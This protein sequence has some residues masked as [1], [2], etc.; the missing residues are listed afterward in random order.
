MLQVGSSWTTLPTTLPPSVGTATNCSSVVFSKYKLVVVASGEGSK[1]QASGGSGELGTI[2]SL[3]R[4]GS[5]KIDRPLPSL[6]CAANG[7][8]SGGNSGNKYLAY[9]LGKSQPGEFVSSAAPAVLAQN[10]FLY[11]IVC[12]NTTPVK[13]SNY[14]IQNKKNVHGYIPQE[15]LYVADLQAFMSKKPGLI[16]NVLDFLGSVTCALGVGSNASKKNAM[17]WNPVMEMQD[18]GSSLAANGTVVCAVGGFQTLSPKFYEV[19]SAKESVSRAAH[20]MILPPPETNANIDDNNDSEPAAPAATA[21]AVGWIRLPDMNVR[22]KNLCTVIVDHYLYA[23]GGQDE[24]GKALA[25]AE[26]LN[27]SLLPGYAAATIKRA[28]VKA[29]AVTRMEEVAWEPVASMRTPRF[30]F[31]VTAT[32]TGVENAIIIAGGCNTANGRLNSVECLVHTTH[33]Q[34]GYDCHPVWKQLP[35]MQTPRMGAALSIINSKLVISGGSKTPGPFWGSGAL[36]TIETL[37]IVVPMIGEGQ[38]ASTR[39]SSPPTAPLPMPIATAEVFCEDD[40]EGDDGFVSILHHGPPINPSHTSQRHHQQPISVASLASQVHP[41]APT[42]EDDVYP[43]EVSV[44]LPLP[45]PPPCLPPQEER[46]STLSPLPPPLLP[47]A[48]AAAAVPAHRENGELPS[49]DD[50]SC[51]ICLEHKKQVAFFCGH[52]ACLKCAPLVDACH[53]CRKPIEGRIQLFG[54]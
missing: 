10:R 26:R 17:F 52:Q 28:P 46:S 33:E 23:I 43:V 1:H 12:N 41:S 54:D 6:I 51:A 49:D 13:N 42:T 29:S 45:I 4:D 2:L 9:A 38:S 47:P 25:S 37:D 31:S 22:R 7:S 3:R 21:T 27:L 11:T 14:I 50:L 53:I 15:E 20:M 48:A 19:F 24:S 16:T 30:G 34:E 8:L 35:N 36:D 44:E 40:G 5:W 18:C 32:S 39:F